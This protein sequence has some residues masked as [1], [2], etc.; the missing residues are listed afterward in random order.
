MIWFSVALGGGADQDGLGVY[1]VTQVN[2][3]RCS[4]ARAYLQ[5][6]VGVRSNLHV[7]TRT[8]A[9]RILFEGQRAVGVE[10]LPTRESAKWSTIARKIPRVRQVPCPNSS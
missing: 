6:W 10:V 1:Q 8:H 4:A 7:L 9:Q 3:E 2:G 5:P